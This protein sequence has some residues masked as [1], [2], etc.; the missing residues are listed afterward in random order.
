MRTR[1]PI[2]A[3]NLDVTFAFA[4][5]VFYSIALVKQLKSTT[6]GGIISEDKL[7][8]RECWETG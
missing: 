8:L 2:A 7:S 4:V 1:I 5:V 6:D 3:M